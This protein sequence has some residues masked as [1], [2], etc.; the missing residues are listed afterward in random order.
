MTRKDDYGN[1]HEFD[2][3]RIPYRRVEL[4][5]W[6]PEVDLALLYDRRAN[7]DTA[8]FRSDPVDFGDGIASFGYPAS[9]VLSY[10]GNG[11]QGNV[12]GLSGMLNMPHPNKYF[13]HTAP[14]QE[15][16]SGGPILDLTGNVVGVT[17]YGMV[18]ILR[19]GQRTIKPPQNVNFAIK[20]DVIQKFLK[21]NNIAVNPVTKD[22][23]TENSD[24]I[25][26]QEIYAKARKFTVPVLCFDNK[27]EKPFEGLDGTSDVGIY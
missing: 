16:N 13:Q 3:F 20:F 11:T 24:R 14:I 19:S 18:S 8:T 26:L 15:G 6:D 2:D 10:R 17:E 22:K 9:D 1:R 21:E 23:D 12:S 27:V 4:I 5:A 7:T 25:S